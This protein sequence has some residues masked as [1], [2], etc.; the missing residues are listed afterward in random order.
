MQIGKVTRDMDHRDLPL[1]VAILT[2]ATDHAGDDQSGVVHSLAKANAV[3][4][5]FSLRSM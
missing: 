3:D 2:K 4:V 5:R 1:A